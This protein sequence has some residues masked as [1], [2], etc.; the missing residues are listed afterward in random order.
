MRFSKIS[1]RRTMK[2]LDLSSSKMKITRLA[3]II[4]EIEI[5]KTHIELKRNAVTTNT[6]TSILPLPFLNADVS[7][8]VYLLWFP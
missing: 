6:N 3:D 4:V 2:K 1:N 5:E 8:Y 7:S